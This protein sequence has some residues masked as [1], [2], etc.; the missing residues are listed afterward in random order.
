MTKRVFTLWHSVVGTGLLLIV[1]G[2]LL[3]H[4]EPKAAIWLLLLSAA[5]GAIGNIYVSTEVIQ[6]VRNAWHMLWLLS[7][8]V[9]EF[10]IFFALQ[11]GYLLLLQPGS[12]PS[13][14]ARPLPLLLH[15]IMVFVFNPLYI[16]VTSWGQ[17]LLI[18]NTLGS[19]AL[20]LFILQNIGQFRRSTQ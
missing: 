14:S 7:V 13:L 15:S 17:E 8:I 10:V 18:I 5:V 16:P 9:G 2:L 11:Y 4:L 12:F 6:E 19:L 20:V 1:E 3:W